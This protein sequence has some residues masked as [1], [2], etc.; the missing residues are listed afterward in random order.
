M[1]WSASIR[2]LTAMIQHSVSFKATWILRFQLLISIA[3]ISACE[4]EEI[5]RPQTQPEPSE[6]PLQVREWY[7]A[8]K[9][10]RQPTAYVPPTATQLQP[11]MAPAAN[12]WNS[13]QQPWGTATQQPVYSAPQYVSPAQP[14]G[15]QY[16]QPSVWAGQ[17]PMA[18]RYQY[19]YAPRPWGSI[20][21]PNSQQNAPVSTDA[22]PQ[23][24]YGYSAPWGVPQT[25]G[26]VGGAPAVQPGQVPGTVYYDTNW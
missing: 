23:G 17:Q 9:H 25:G 3:L 5:T 4:N 10:R 22:W 13:I 24:G 7:P 18:P 11:V 16:Q 26:Y 6:A 8:P 2:Q 1:R 20:T 14:A 21:E 15:S 19:Q 12:Q